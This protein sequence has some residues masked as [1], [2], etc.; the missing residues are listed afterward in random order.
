MDTDGSVET[1]EHPHYWLN[2]KT[3]TLKSQ[4]LPMKMPGAKT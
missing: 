3:A 1:P 2:D 4:C